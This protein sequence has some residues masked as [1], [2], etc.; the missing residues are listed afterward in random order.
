MRVL[1]YS[2]SILIFLV[3]VP[4]CNSAENNRPASEQ[5][6]A[7]LVTGASSGIGRK[8]TETLA[9]QGYFVYAG[10]RKQRDME[11]LNRIDNVQSIRLDVTIQDDINAAIE[12]VRNGGRGLYGLVNNA[13]TAF[14]GP[15]IEVGVEDLKWLFDV[16]VFG[17]YRI[18]QAFAPFIIESRGRII[19]IG[20]I[21]GILSGTFLGQ[22]SMTKHAIEAYTD[23]LAQEMARFNV[24]VSVIEPGNYRS[25][26]GNAAVEFMRRNNYVKEGSPYAEQLQ[27]FMNRPSDRSQYKEPDEVA[28][29]VMLALFDNNPKQRYMV[30]PNR[31]EASVTIN[32]SI[33]K[34]IELNREQAYSFSRD[35]LIA[36][37]DA[38]LGQ[39]SE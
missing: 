24:K 32:R 37:L 27:Q 25:D 8:I 34:V 26:I 19:N 38:A 39:S 1:L 29:A 22:Y 15:L 20:S 16:N 21:S 14:G 9:A 18:T 10:A 13:G 23:A 11:E 28:D 5:Q 36:M 17:V 31:G 4:P 7:V 3:S 33:Q 30:V 6:N 2:C 12:T 35:E